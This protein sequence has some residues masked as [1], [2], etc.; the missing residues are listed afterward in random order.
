MIALDT[1]VL[2]R[3]FAQDD[4]EQSAKATMLIESLT[5]AQQGFISQ[6][7]LVETVWVMQR[8][9][10]ADR[11]T[12]SSIIRNML[13]I[14]GFLLE[15]R[16][17]VKKTVDSYATSNADFAD[18]LIAKTAEFYGCQSVITFDIK[19]A[20]ACGMKLLD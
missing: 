16:E 9:F 11:E 13:L 3:Y 20:K 8:V 12:V 6:V 19:A 5:D 4:I 18:C 14:Q 10:E 1:N 7:V 17:V 2:V 15:S